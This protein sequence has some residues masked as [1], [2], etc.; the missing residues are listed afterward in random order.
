MFDVAADRELIFW[1]GPYFMGPQGLYLNKW[2][3]DFDPSQDVSSAVPVWVRLLHLPLHCWS[4]D[5]LES[6]GNEL[7]KYI[8]RADRK[9]QFSC[10]QICVKVDLEIGLPEAIKLTVADWSHIQELDYEQIPFKCRFYHG[11]DHF[12][13]GWYKIEEDKVNEKEEQWMQV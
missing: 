8:D 13:R 5:A 6:I 9:Y 11:Y 2:T 1:N 3:P 7:G 10:A 12:A 4:S